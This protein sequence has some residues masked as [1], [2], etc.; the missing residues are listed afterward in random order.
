MRE[1]V[2][3]SLYFHKRMCNLEEGQDKFIHCTVTAIRSI[4]WYKTTAYNT[5]YY[6]YKR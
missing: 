3:E 2:S 1:T 5:K 4:T 6:D